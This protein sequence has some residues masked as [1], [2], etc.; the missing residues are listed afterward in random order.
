MHSRF[1]RWMCIFMALLMVIGL[2]FT[3]VA[4]IAAAV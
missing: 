4:S 3:I 1:V 2:I